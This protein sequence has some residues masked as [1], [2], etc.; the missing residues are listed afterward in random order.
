MKL[1]QIIKNLYIKKIYSISFIILSIF[2]LI[3]LI[4][5]SP[6]LNLSYTGKLNLTENHI[7][8]DKFFYEGD[9]VYAKLNLFLKS[10]YKN[11]LISADYAEFSRN[12]SYSNLSKT[13]SVDFPLPNMPEKEGTTTVEFNII[14]CKNPF[15]KSEVSK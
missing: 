9:L 8:F 2:T 10:D 13:S 1:N 14:S 11:C 15:N 4:I 6:E 12:E 7:N 5:F 3:L